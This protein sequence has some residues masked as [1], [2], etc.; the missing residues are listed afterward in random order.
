MIYGVGIASHIL[1][2]VMTSFGTRMWFPLS[3]R[4]FA[5]DLLFIVDFSF[6]TIMLRR[7]SLRGSAAIRRKAAAAR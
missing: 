7:R 6:T 3:S 1:L 5:W 4:R 2:D